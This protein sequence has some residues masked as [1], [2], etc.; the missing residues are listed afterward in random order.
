M[1][2]STTDQTSEEGQRIFVGHF[3][4]IRLFAV[5]EPPQ[6]SEARTEERVGQDHAIPA[7]DERTPRRTDMHDSREPAA[8]FDA[9]L[10]AWHHQRHASLVLFR[11]AQQR[12]IRRW[13]PP[14]WAW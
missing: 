14:E 8:W 1:L 3:D 2:G 7:I 5:E 4:D 13:I 12:E 9:I 11:I 6:W 10:R